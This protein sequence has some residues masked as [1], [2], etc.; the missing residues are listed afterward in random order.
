MLAEKHDIPRRMA[1]QDHAVNREHDPKWRRCV[2]VQLERGSGWLLE[3]LCNSIAVRFEGRLNVGELDAGPDQTAGPCPVAA[4][5]GMG[6]FQ[7]ISL[8]NWERIASQP[9]AAAIFVDDPT[10]TPDDAAVV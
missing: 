10:V 7:L 3:P 2:R 9:V 5:L 8:S 6:N 4:K 1:I